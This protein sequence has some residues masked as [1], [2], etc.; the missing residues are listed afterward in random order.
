MGH[1]GG[2]NLA[3]H[4]LPFV[5]LNLHI[6]A[7]FNCT[8]NVLSWNMILAF[9]WDKLLGT[10]FLPFYCSWVWAILYDCIGPGWLWYLFKHLQVWYLFKHL[11]V[12]AI[13]YIFFCVS[14][15]IMSAKLRKSLV[16]GLLQWQTWFAL[17]NSCSHQ[18]TV[19]LLFIHLAILILTALWAQLSSK[20]FLELELWE[21]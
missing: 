21:Y 8:F 15:E 17:L 1:A 3:L 6:V 7:P 10:S 20:I 14:V 9:S 11:Q 2:T 18:L 12:R 4:S 19:V 16:T 13:L 5:I